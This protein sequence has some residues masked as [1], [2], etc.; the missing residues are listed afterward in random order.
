MFST[1][2]DGVAA[3]FARSGNAVAAALSAQRSLAAEERTEAVTLRVRMGLHTGEADE[4][5]GDYFGPTLNTAA[6]LMA[7]GH[8]GQVLLS[9]ST[10]A[11]VRRSLPRGAQL[12]SLGP[13][14]LKDLPSV[15]EV[16]QLVHPDLT[17]EFPALRSLGPAMH[18][19][20]RDHELSQLGSGLDLAAAGHGSMW[21]L[22]GAPGV[23]KSRLLFEL[24][25]R[26]RGRGF[27]VATGRCLEQEG[28]PALWPWRQVLAGLLAGCDAVEVAS[29]LGPAASELADL[30]PEGTGIQRQPDDRTSSTSF[31]LMDAM[32]STLRRM[33]GKQPTVVVIDDVHWADASS[34]AALQFAAGFLED[35]P[36]MI[37]ATLCP[38]RAGQGT[39]DAAARDPRQDPPRARHDLAVRRRPRRALGADI[40]GALRGSS[41]RRISRFTD[42]S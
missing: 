30:L 36:L 28:S 16:L 38:P 18:L 1:G 35:A 7:A 40:G 12:R 8:G 27:R 19:V 11:L 13:H 17:A 33:A 26:A 32:S 15:G 31:R 21:L 14:H 5:D 4:R 23:G 2:G 3:A 39:S 29:L 22:A 25:R 20:G 37:I 6:R 41:H 34:L 24:A 42:P 10:A 9:D